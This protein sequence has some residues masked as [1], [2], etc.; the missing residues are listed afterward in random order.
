MEKNKYYEFGQQKFGPFLFGFVRWLKNELVRRGFEKVFF[1]SR[2]GYMMQKAFDIINDTDIVSQYVY[3]S[4]RSLRQPL[5]HECTDFEDSLKYLS[6]ERYISFGK[7][8]EYYGYDES[9]KSKVAAECGIN[10]EE[11][12]PYDDVAK[13][14]LARKL[15][16]DNRES[17]IRYSR[18]QDELLL[19]YTE[20]LNMRGRFAI[21]DIGWH[22]NMQRYLELYM[23]SHGYDV[24]FEGFY[25]GILPDVELTTEVHGYIYSPQNPKPYKKLLSFFGVSEKLLQGFEGSTAGYTRIEDG[26]IG[27]KLMAYEYEGDQQVISAIQ[28]WQS[29]ALDYVRSCM[30]GVDKTNQISVDASDEQLTKPLIR[31]GMK[32]S[33]KDTNLF[34]FFYNTD[35]TNAYYTAQKSLFRYRPKEL[36]HALADS[37]W[38]TGF[39]KSVFKVPLPYYLVYRILKK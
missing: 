17:I 28:S 2:D 25:I 9:E 20:Q 22:G 8:L 18:E 19:E 23:K 14:E 36:V 6:K 7:L 39:M 4:R 31:F 38:K 26:L 12:M 27:P 16:E 29:G 10:L 33:L 30:D 34:S 32:P 24:S 35:G 13:N 11:T 15:Y 1:F 5:I 3:V 21:V 37:P